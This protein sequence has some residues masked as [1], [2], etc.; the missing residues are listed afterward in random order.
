MEKKESPYTSQRKRLEKRLV[1]EVVSSPDSVIYNL[2]RGYNRRILSYSPRALEDN[3]NQNTYMN[4]HYVYSGL[5][6][7]IHN[8][9]SSERTRVEKEI[10]KLVN[11]HGYLHIIIKDISDWKGYVDYCNYYDEPLLNK[12]DFN[13]LVKLIKQWRILSANEHYAL[14]KQEK[15]NIKL[16]REKTKKMSR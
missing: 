5:S 8:D 4:D 6:Q 10:L 15:R 11:I 13:H 14:T 7:A 1:R 9:M 2:E 16:L 3:T 12:E